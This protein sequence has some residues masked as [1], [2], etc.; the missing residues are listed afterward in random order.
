LKTRDFRQCQLFNKKPKNL[1]T[2]LAPAWSRCHSNH[3]RQSPR[4]CL[5]NRR[6]SEMTMAMSFIARQIEIPHGV[7]D[8]KFTDRITLTFPSYSSQE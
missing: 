3:C 7:L 6:L 4:R 5:R 2:A 1:E 8:N